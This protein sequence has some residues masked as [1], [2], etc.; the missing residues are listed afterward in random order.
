[1]FENY[2]DSPNLPPPSRE[3]TCGWSCKSWPRCRSPQGGFVQLRHLRWQQT[4]PSVPPGAQTFSGT[5]S[6]PKPHQLRPSWLD[7]QISSLRSHSA[8]G[9]ATHCNWSARARH[10]NLHKLRTRN[11]HCFYLQKSGDSP[12][13]HVAIQDPQLCLVEFFGNVRHVLRC[14]L[15]I[16]L[17]HFLSQQVDF[18]LQM[19]EVASR[20]HMTS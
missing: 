15:C 20:P 16:T 10:P 19:V 13:H 14:E 18:A 17:R 12:R 7:D 5:P 9:I 3:Q 1:M 11:C 8:P 2:L 4:S 6:I